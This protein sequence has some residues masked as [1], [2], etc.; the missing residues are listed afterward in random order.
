[1]DRSDMRSPLI[2]DVGG[3]HGTSVHARAEGS[4]VVGQRALH[5][6]SRGI[7]VPSGRAAHRSRQN[8][9][10]HGSVSS[11]ADNIQ[12][13]TFTCACLRESSTSWCSQ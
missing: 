2:A 3:P 13:E 1:M 8:N 5:A 11:S 10:T 9:H 4:P 6:Y 7:S 12:L